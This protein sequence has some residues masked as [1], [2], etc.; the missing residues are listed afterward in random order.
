MVIKQWCAICL[1]IA[2]ILLL[3]AGLA[4][5]DWPLQF[6]TVA[7]LLYAG[8]IAAVA[9]LVILPLKKL[10]QHSLQK[11]SLQTQLNNWA[12]DTA[13]YK[14]LAALQPQSDT[15]PWPNELQ[16]GSEKAPIHITVACSPHCQPCAN[17]HRLLDELL[18]KMPES[19]CLQVRFT[20]QGQDG[21]DRGYS[22]V[23]QILQQTAQA[24]TKMKEQILK[25]WFA[26]MDE[27]KFKLTYPPKKTVDVTETINRNA[28]WCQQVGIAFTPT[29]F[30]NGRQAPGQYGVSDLVKLLPRLANE[31]T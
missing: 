14:A 25:D 19:F 2:G 23:Q 21:S 9:G 11:N 1:G 28:A 13:V 6:S 15:A 16:L 26:N 10:L 17:A 27:E 7:V 24:T 22:A 8:S 30:I 20:V 5:A 4:L 29:I 18:E 12:A 3:Q 31:A